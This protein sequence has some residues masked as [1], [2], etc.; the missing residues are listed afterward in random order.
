MEAIANQPK[1]PAPKGI[2]VEEAAAM[3][4]Y[5]TATVRRLI[6][7]HILIAWKPAGPHGR[8]WLIDEVSLSRLQAALI[9]RARSH[10]AP[11]QTALLQGELPL[12]W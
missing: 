5:S 1:I 3:L 2:T 7:S 12:M 10:A 4:R 8:K 11:V 6:A 9:D